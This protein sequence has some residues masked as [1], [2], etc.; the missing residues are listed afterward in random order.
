MRGVEQCGVF[1]ST[2]SL[3]FKMKSAHLIQEGRAYTN[4]LPL[5]H[6][7]Q[8]SCLIVAAL[9]HRANGKVGNWIITGEADEVLRRDGH[10]Q[11]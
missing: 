8:T 4:A 9:K 7:H 11:V 2:S 5:R 1:P 10:G 6:D 3:P